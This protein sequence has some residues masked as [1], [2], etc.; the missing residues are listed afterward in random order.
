LLG[1]G[2]ISSFQELIKTFKSKTLQGIETTSVGAYLTFSG[3]RTIKLWDVDSAREL[4]TLPNNSMASFISFSP[5]QPV[6]AVSNED[7]TIK[8]WDIRTESLIASTKCSV[9]PSSIAITGDGAILLCADESNGIVRRW[10]LKSFGEREPIHFQMAGLTE[11]R[12]S[13]D[14]SLIAAQ[15]SHGD[16]KI[17]DIQTSQVIWELPTARL[18]PEHSVSF[19]LQNNR[20]ATV[21]E[22]EA[23][24]LWHRT[25]S[26]PIADEER[27]IAA[28]GIHTVAFSRD[29]Q[30]LA[31]ASEV[32]D[33]VVL[34]SDTWQEIERLRSYSNRI[35]AAGFDPN[36]PALAIQLWYDSHFVWDLTKGGLVDNNGI[37]ISYNNRNDFL[38]NKTLFGNQ[39]S[40]NNR[41][42]YLQL[43][44]KD[45]HEVC[46][47]VILDKQ[48]AWVA[49][50]PDGRFDTNMDLS[51]IA[52][53]HWILSGKSLD[54]LPLEIFMRD[55]YEP[56]LLPRLLSYEGMA[57]LPSLTELNR[58]QPEVKIM[59]ARRGATPDEV[60]VEVEALA[61]RGSTQPNGKTET[62]AYD[63]RLFRTGNWSVSG[64][65]LHME[66]LGHRI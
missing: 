9:R 39:F 4:M 33:I 12:I 30:R 57:R 20:V 27:T 50:A 3:D 17:V 44:D 21:K 41:Q 65:F 5:I 61:K 60:L 14:G 46:T 13:Q 35:E 11:W 45:G 22:Y 32:G 43:Q 48:N 26:K 36:S 40:V 10:D 47:L 66:W 18:S 19:A 6:L 56:R 38:A 49:V 64:Q 31:Y 1:S 37:V 24:T 15:D 16:I 34:G 63:L 42:D 28:P 29:G 54:P 23:L 25:A 58:I 59:G 51:N 53:V 7:G 62:A 2:W 52:G 8:I 55:Y